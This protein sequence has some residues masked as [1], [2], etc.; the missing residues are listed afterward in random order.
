MARFFSQCQTTSVHTEVF[1][2]KINV[3]N[4]IAAIFTATG[5]DIACVHESRTGQLYFEKKENG[6]Y[7]NFH[8]PNLVIGTVGGGFALSQKNS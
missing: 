2:L 7:A 5:Q 4:V 8:L 3:A 1:G 6:L